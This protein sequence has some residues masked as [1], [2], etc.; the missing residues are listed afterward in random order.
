MGTPE[1]SKPHL[2][3]APRRAFLNSTYAFLGAVSSTVTGILVVRYLGAANLG[4]YSV[5][6][7][8][9]PYFSIL[10]NLGL[11]AILIREMVRDPERT[12]RLLANGIALNIC[13]SV[14]AMGICWLAVS[15]VP[16]PPDVRFLVR[17][18]AVSLLFGFSTL[19][20]GVFQARVE[21]QYSALAAVIAKFAFV[22]MVIGLVIVKA[23]LSGFILANLAWAAIQVLVLC[24]FLRN[25]VH[26]ALAA[27]LH[28]WRYLLS[29]S[30]PLALS[31]IFIAIYGR[32]DQLMLYPMAGPTATGL[33]AAAVKVGEV[34]R[35]I[36]V[37]FM[38]T[39]FPLLSQR[40]VSSSSS[41][42]KLYDMSF[43]YLGSAIVLIAIWI[44]FS[45]EPLLN[46]L[47]GS[48]YTS[49]ALALTVLT[50]SEIWVFLGVVNQ[51]VLVA[52]GLQRIDFVLTSVAAAANVVLN[53]I[54]IPRCGIL[55]ASIATFVAYGTGAVLE[56]FLRPTRPF[57][58]SM[59]R[60]LT[61]PLTSAAITAA[62]CWFYLPGSLFLRT[63][64]VCAVFVV[65]LA[66]LGGITREDRD[67]A[68][69]VIF[70]S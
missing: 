63:I 42:A 4:K 8:F 68:T 57:A 69:K 37:A 43:R 9:I 2:R 23:G 46:L 13:L 5:A 67:L 31:G 28:I 39:V 54:L 18:Y 33:Y 45:G 66:L 34:F 7:A 30:W 29:E 50:W 52:S 17:L 38:A 19:L 26:L 60:G 51:Q 12:D 41:F 44:T 21:M 25:R 15:F 55:G 1:Q 36:P 24:A 27:D 65:I 56:L 32:I 59:F 61:K 53:L 20:G 10:A 22:A 14:I 40:F 11:A 70:G 47:Y 16:Y 64:Q 35:F 6:L 49:G 62:I 48:R 3:V 58:F